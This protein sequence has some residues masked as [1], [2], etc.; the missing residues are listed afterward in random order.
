[1]DDVAARLHPLLDDEATSRAIAVLRR[2]FLEHNGPGPRR[3]AEFLVGR[4]DDSV[5][6]DVVGFVRRLLECST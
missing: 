4:P 5:Q 1:V 6:A 2:D 3:V